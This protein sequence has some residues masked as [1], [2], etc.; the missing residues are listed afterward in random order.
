[1]PLQFV[2]REVC[3]LC[4]KPSP[5][6]LCELS[7]ECAP[8]APFLESFYAGRLD[9]A[10]LS[11]GC[12]R[13]LQ[14]DACGFLYQDPIL[15]DA[16][17][18]ELYQ[19]WVDQAKSLDKKKNMSASRRR[20]YA[21][22]LELIKRLFRRAPEQVRVLDYGMG[23]GY[24]CKMALDEGFDTCGY[25]LSRSRSQHARGLG[26]PVLDDLDK[27]A[28]KFDFIYANQ[29]FE[30]LPDPVVV[31]QELVQRL[32]C[33]GYVYLRVPDGRGLAQSLQRHGW[34]PAL[35][36][37]HPLEH[38]NC[39]TRATLIQLAA[40]AGLHHVS[41]PWRIRWKSPVGSLRREIADRWFTTH[42]LLQR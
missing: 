11:E 19:D 9:S 14:C 25:E 22:Q 27:G 13:V 12:Y 10:R 29:V 26:V 40:K 6:P 31:L 41:A 23:W 38:I 16:G 36:A 15:G 17:M 33:D 1:M 42:L 8:L 24:W 2:S 3:P 7:F 4:A 20:Q 37:V 35:D 30:H 34:T 21:G 18:G 28:G 32:E 5:S 39:F